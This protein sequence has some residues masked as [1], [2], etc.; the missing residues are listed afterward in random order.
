MSRAALL[1]EIRSRVLPALLA[2]RD[3][4]AIAAAVSNGRTRP[5]NREIGNGLV[6]ETVGLDV[7]NKILDAVAA[8]PE[9]RHVRPLLEQGRLSSSS[10]LMAQWLSGLAAGG[11]IP[12]E[13]AE[14]LIAL[15]CEPAP[16]TEE[17]VRRACW[18]DAGEWLP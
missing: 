15:G 4:H 3:H 16:V 11:T 2:T 1:A 14:A 18:S 9:M 8:A 13:A 7:G 17:D 10:P 12:A 6:I 5:T